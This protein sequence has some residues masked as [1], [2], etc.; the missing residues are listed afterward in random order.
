MKS[1]EGGRV[2]E[3]SHVLQV[4]VMKIECW[5]LR[6]VVERGRRIQV[7]LKCFSSSASPAGFNIPTGEKGGKSRISKL[8]V[9][10][11]AF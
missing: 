10:C 8:N 7:S 9:M 3:K 6:N 1:E 11:V 2:S 5:K 4:F